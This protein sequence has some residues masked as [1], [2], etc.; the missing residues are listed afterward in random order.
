MIT[1]TDATHVLTIRV[2]L[3]VD[4]TFD[5]NPLEEALRVIM[6]LTRLATTGAVC[7]D[8]TVSVSDVRPLLIPEVTA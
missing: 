6:P 4:E 2:P 1:R 3:H 5:F 8:I 7:D